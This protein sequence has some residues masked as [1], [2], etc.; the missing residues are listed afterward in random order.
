MSTERRPL[1]PQDLLAFKLPGNAQISP[2]G[3]RVAFMLQQIDAEKNEYKTSIWIAAE[4]RP[5]APFTRGPKDSAPRWSPDGRY[6]A[7]VSSRSGSAQIWLLPLDGGEARQLTRIKGG[8][9]NP[10]WSPD[11]KRLA[12]TAC[13]TAD[14]IQPETKEEEEK[15]P[16]KKFTKDVKV[17]TRLHYKMDGVGYYTEKRSQVC[18]IGVDESGQPVQLTDGDFNHGDLSWTPDGTEVLFVAD[19]R[20]DAEYHR[21]NDLWAVGAAG[22]EE[23]MRLLPDGHNL[24]VAGASASPDGRSVAFVGTMGSDQGYGVKRLYLLDRTNGGLRCVTPHFDRGFGN[25][26]IYDMPGARRRTD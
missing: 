18:V 24:S 6:L 17:I 5:P 13:A 26:G 23:P 14:G 7:F 25:E 12:F 4:G 15:D 21:N 8:C 2:D 11:G 1:S 16:Y 19:R 22:G 20:P 9:G 10:V 3:R